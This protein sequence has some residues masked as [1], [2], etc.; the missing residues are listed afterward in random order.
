MTIDSRKSPFDVLNPLI[1]F[2]HIIPIDIE[3]L[4]N[5]VESFLKRSNAK[6]SGSAIR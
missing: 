3:Q 1:L 5:V 6:V 2:Q 4:E